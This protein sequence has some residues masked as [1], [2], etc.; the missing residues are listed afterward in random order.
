MSTSDDRIPPHS[1]EAEQGIL[2]CALLDPQLAPELSE[3][4]A[5]NG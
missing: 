3:E 1:P 5:Q 2:G 4:I